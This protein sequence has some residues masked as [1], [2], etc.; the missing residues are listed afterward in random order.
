MFSCSLF[1]ATLL[2][3][4][5]MLVGQNNSWLPGLF[6]GSMVATN[7]C[8]PGI[9]SQRN[10]AKG[11]I[12]RSVSQSVRQT[13]TPMGGPFG[14][15]VHHWESEGSMYRYIRS[16]HRSTQPG[17]QDTKAAEA[18]AS[19]V[20]WLVGSLTLIIPALVGFP[21]DVVPHVH[22]G[23]DPTACLQIRRSESDVCRTTPTKFTTGRMN[24]PLGC[25]CANFCPLRERHLAK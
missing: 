2:V 7:P 25:P 20:A 12:R 3:V 1:V 21:V 14:M 8:L 16:T 11:T 13:R 23:K 24:K 10:A 17:R 19:C 15:Q 6:D 4:D 18:S 5:I 22:R 9:F